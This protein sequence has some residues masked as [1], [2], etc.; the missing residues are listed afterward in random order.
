MITTGSSARHV[1]RQPTG[2]V[3][4]RTAN[5]RALDYQFAILTNDE[6]L[7]RHLDELLTSLVYPGPAAVQY[8][9]TRDSMQFCDHFSL[10]VDGEELVASRRPGQTLGRMF[11]HINQ[12]AVVSVPGSIVLHA[13]AV[14]RDGR[15][16]ILPAP[17]ESGKTT[18]SAG[19]TAAGMGYLTDEAVAIDRST[20]RLQGYPKP[21]SIDR[22]SWQ[23]LADLEPVLPPDVRRYFG[24]QWQV[25]PEWVR[26]GAVSR[27]A[28]PAVIVCPRYEVGA[29]TVLEPM[30]RVDALQ[31]LLQQ[32]FRVTAD[33]KANL[34]V[35]AEVARRSSCYSLTVGDLDEACTL[36]AQVTDDEEGIR[37][38]SA[39]IS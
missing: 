16:V 14:E 3:A 31:V 20:L 39:D 26:P 15:A 21:F 33:V 5:F 1:G 35:L 24:H 27:E 38:A 34:S 13:A 32:T 11:W 37:E 29:R 22:G 7:G 6:V 36:V 8:R 12:R 4:Y 23:V 28:R 10:S 18:L 2:A 19:L 17:M 30:R 25:A 9:L